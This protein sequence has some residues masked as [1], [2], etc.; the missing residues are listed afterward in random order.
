MLTPNRDEAGQKIASEYSCPAALCETWAEAQRMNPRYKKFFVCPRKFAKMCNHDAG[1]AHQAIRDYE[2]HGSGKY[3][4]QQE[5]RD[6]KNTVL[7]ACQAPIKP[8]EWVRSGT[9]IVDARREERCNS[10]YIEEQEEELEKSI[11]SIDLAKSMDS[12]EDSTSNNE[13]YEK[14]IVAFHASGHGEDA[15]D[16][17]KH[18][19]LHLLLATRVI[20]ASA[21]EVES[22]REGVAEE[23]VAKVTE[24]SI[25]DDEFQNGCMVKLRMP[26][27]T[28]YV[29]PYTEV[30]GRIL[31]D[32]GSTTTLINEDFARRQG[33]VIE[34][35]M[36]NVTLRD[37]N[38]GTSII[39]KQCFLR[40][41]LTTVWGDQVSA[42][43]LALCVKN[44]GHDLL[45]GTR[46]LERYK[47]SV[48]PHR[49]EAQMH[50]GDAIEVFPM[51]D[52]RQ[53]KQLQALTGNDTTDC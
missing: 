46:D 49:G 51:L 29:I 4:S 35:S 31:A 17:I 50:I 52:G 42:T 5:R 2:E 10:S 14:V 41:T 8:G 37:V 7:M 26:Y 44:L 18:S 23:A 33:L 19:A 9:R 47:V 34:K 36:K 43:L 12:E 3:R 40:L 28:E 38:N 15:S 11:E 1:R 24:E 53:I 48:I 39:D 22:F 27:G 13:D 20:P 32:T 25:T 21:A 6:F 16:T 30:Q 45:L